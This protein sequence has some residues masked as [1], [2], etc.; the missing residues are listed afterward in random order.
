MRIRNVNYQTDYSANNSKNSNNIVSFASLK[1]QAIKY[2]VIKKVDELKNLPFGE[3]CL[4]F[5]KKMLGRYNVINTKNESTYLRIGG[6]APFNLT[7]RGNIIIERNLKNI[8]TY[9]SEGRINLSGTIQRGTLS[10]ESGLIHRE[11]SLGEVKAKANN[12][13]TIR[14]AI[15]KKAKVEADEICIDTTGEM[16][17]KVYAH[18]KAKIYGMVLE[19]GEINA[20]LVEV[21][22]RA[23]I[24][25]KINS[26]EI[27]YK[28]D[29]VKPKNISSEKEP[30]QNYSDVKKI[31]VEKHLQKGTVN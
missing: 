17:G 4:L 26:P 31:L 27:I 16:N 29:K 23:K 14:G 28:E 5:L 1:P 22:P 30:N 20:P 8:G 6:I 9:I 10:S 11:G 25:G 15:S 3:R 12:L 21:Y 18:K 2:P 7:T 19:D 13:F 24:L